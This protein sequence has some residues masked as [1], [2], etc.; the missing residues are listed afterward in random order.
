[1]AYLEDGDL[2]RADV[3]KNMR[4]AGL[5]ARERRRRVERILRRWIKHYHYTPDVVAMETLV[6][7]Q[8]N[9]NPHRTQFVNDIK[10]FCTR[11][12]LRVEEYAP[13]AVH[14]FVCPE[15]RVTQL[16]IAEVIAT[17]YFPWLYRFYEKEAA[18]PWYEPLRYWTTMF[19]AIAVALTAAGERA[20]RDGA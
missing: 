6:S 11:D 15:S 16:R 10:R 17:K 18:K 9:Q 3:E 8:R 2:I 20:E 5:S 7:R 12:G 13:Q 14:R 4:H 19:D 1:M